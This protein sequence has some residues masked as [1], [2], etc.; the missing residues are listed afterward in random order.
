MHL[1]NQQ[2]CRYIQYT[3]IMWKEACWM[4]AIPNMFLTSQSGWSWSSGWLN[5]LEIRSGL[6]EGVCRALCRAALGMAW[7]L[8]WGSGGVCRFPAESQEIPAARRLGRL[9]KFRGSGS[10]WTMLDHFLWRWIPAALKA[11]LSHDPT[12]LRPLQHRMQGNYQV[13]GKDM[14]DPEDL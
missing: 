3:Y 12:D 10:S 7:F 13:S 5:P 1:Y 11:P 9:G 2:V 6:D 14:V 4:I 8:R